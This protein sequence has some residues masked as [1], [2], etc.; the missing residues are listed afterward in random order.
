MTAN[1][2]KGAT[3]ANQSRKQRRAAE[4]AARKRSGGASA[5]SSGSGGRS[6]PSIL[7]VSAAAIAVGL[8]VV[9]ALVLLS[10]GLGNDAAAVSEPDTPA[11]PTELRQGRTL[12]AP[13][14][15]PEVS[16]EVF[17]D[18]QCPHCQTFTERVEPLLIAKHVTSGTASLTYRDYVIYG[19]TS[20]DAAVAMRAADKLDDAFW[21]YHHVLYHNA[22]D[23]SFSRD[24]LA[25]IAEVVGLDRAEFE[26]LLDD[27]ELLAGVVDDMA[28]G[29]DYGATGTPAVVVNGQLLG[30]PSWEDL[31]AA[32][33]NAAAQ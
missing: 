15:S 19:E 24:W 23:G 20:S 33:E 9:V 2:D 18:P 1:D 28:R 29:S 26:S 30:S 25:D 6:G 16:V 32:I 27:E 4:R 7:I 8:V 11:P 22:G 5:N 31:D 13:E 12:V 14:A 17:E 21:D 10:G 3:G